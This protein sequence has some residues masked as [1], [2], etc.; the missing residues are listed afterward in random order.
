M[1]TPARVDIDMDTD[2]NRDYRYETARRRQQTLIAT[3]KLSPWD[4]GEDT[5]AADD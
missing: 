3:N 4:I 5:G 1:R 2:P